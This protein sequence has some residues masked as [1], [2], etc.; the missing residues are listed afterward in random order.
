MR[1]SFTLMPPAV[2]RFFALACAITWLCQLPLLLLQWGAPIPPAA[3]MAPLVLGAVGPS[4][5]AL[6]CAWREGG[7]AGLSGLFSPHRAPAGWGYA[8]LALCLP[9]ALHLLGLALLALAGGNMPATLLY[10][11]VTPDQ[12]GIAVLGPAGE[13]LGWRGY[14]LRRLLPSQGP[15]LAS[16]VVGLAWTFWHLP[17]MCLPGVPWW[18]WAL[19]PLFI[20]ALS[21]L[22]TALHIKSRGSLL[23]AWAAHLGIHLDNVSRAHLSGD[24]AAPLAVTTIVALVAAAIIARRMRAWK[25]T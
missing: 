10:T 19:A 14:A 5:A 1:A 6:V 22:M 20:T 17:M 2:V 24:G 25:P 21:V 11:P 9:A 4:A 23:V 13:E 12:R 15:V 8:P 3:A 18:S 16:V 7:R